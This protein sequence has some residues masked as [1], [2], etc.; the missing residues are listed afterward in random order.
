MHLNGVHQIVRS[1]RLLDQ[2]YEIV[3]NRETHMTK[4]T[5][6]LALLSGQPT[7]SLYLINSYNV[8]DKL[9]SIWS[10]D[11]CALYYP[12]D[13]WLHLQHILEYIPN[14][15]VKCGFFEI[16]YKRIKGRLFQFHQFDLKC[17]ALLCRS[18]EGQQRFGAI[19]GVKE[20]YGILKDPL[21]KLDTYENV[22]LTL[23]NGIMSKQ[24]LWRCR[25]FP[26][27]PLVIAELSRDTTNSNM[28]LWCFQVCTSKKCFCILHTHKVILSFYVNWVKCLA[29]SVLQGQRVWKY[30]RSA[31]VCH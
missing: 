11:I 30:C 7:A 4:A 13:L 18:E 14:E 23:T 29:S 10:R 28:Q 8:L 12:E 19:D 31:K 21:A 25:E 9:K 5:Q 22:V 2:I 15:A 1:N 26:D 20:M 6:I 27:L 16:L 24:V 3:I 17:F